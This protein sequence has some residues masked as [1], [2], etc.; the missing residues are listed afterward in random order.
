MA[1]ALA[2]VRTFRATFTE[3]MYDV[4]VRPGDMINPAT[5]GSSASSFAF[6]RGNKPSLWRSDDITTGWEGS[7]RPSLTEYVGDPPSACM[8]ATRTRTWYCAVP[9]DMGQILVADPHPEMLLITIHPKQAFGPTV[10]FVQGSD[11]RVGG[12]DAIPYRYDYIFPAGPT[13]IQG[14]FWIARR[15]ALPLML[16]DTASVPRWS[17]VPGNIDTKRLVWSAWNSPSI[18]IPTMPR[19]PR[20]A[21]VWSGPS[22]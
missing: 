19:R 18:H 5:N 13:H 20:H 22:D 10:R 17:N 14:T 3:R 9:T 4:G 11:G 2:S 6:I 15:T 8:R 12:Q 1:H 21:Y 16:E 7:K